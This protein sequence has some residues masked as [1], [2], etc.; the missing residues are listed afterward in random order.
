[1]TFNFDKSFHKPRE[2]IPKDCPCRECEEP[3]YGIDNPYYC[4][5]KCN[6]C[7]A[8]KDW[9]DNDDQYTIRRQGYAQ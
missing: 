7:K 8:Y 4:S 3:K 9:R 6:E 2:S 1:M 5:T